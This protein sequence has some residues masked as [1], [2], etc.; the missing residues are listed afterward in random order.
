MT[1]QRVI[2]LNR[3]KRMNMTRLRRSSGTIAKFYKTNIVAFVL[4]S[5]VIVLLF[6][7]QDV[8]GQ[9]VRSASPDFVTYI[10]SAFSIH[11]PDYMVEVPSEDS[12]TVQF[13]NT[14]NDTH[15]LISTETK[16]ILDPIQLSDIQNRF[17]AMLIQRGGVVTMRQES[18]INRYPCI[19]SEVHWQLEGSPLCYIA[20]FVDTPEAIFKIYGWTIETQQ[21]YLEDFRT[22]ALSFTPNSS[23]SKFSSAN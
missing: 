6:S 19:L 23:V 11:V 16:Q 10:D 22:A 14:F 18:K 4:M 5:V 20:V 1:P 3:L 9:S 2:I 21:E 17:E 13:Q 8:K 7:M 15:L 12:S